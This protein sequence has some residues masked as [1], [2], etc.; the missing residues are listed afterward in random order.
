MT[1]ILKGHSRQT[2]SERGN[3]ISGPNMPSPI[4]PR[5]GH[6]CV[7]QLFPVTGEMLTAVRP[8]P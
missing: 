5:A 2:P 1:L 7:F 8:L 4:R 3:P 6:V